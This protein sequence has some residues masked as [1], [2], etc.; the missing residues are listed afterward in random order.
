[1]EVQRRGFP[2]IISD[3]DE[4][5]IQMLI[6]VVGSVDELSHVD[7]MKTPF[8]L[9]FRVAPSTPVYFNNLLQEILKLNNMFNIRI[10]MGKSM[11]KNSTI[12]FNIKINNYGEV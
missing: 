12:T 4:V 11:K 8:H 5:F 6:G 10:E 2:E 9:H 1:M 3:N 7:I